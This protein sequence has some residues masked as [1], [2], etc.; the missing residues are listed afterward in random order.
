MPPRL[1][2]TTSRRLFDRAQKVLPGGVS[3]PVRAFRAVGGHPIFVKKAA[4]STLVDVDG[5]RY[6][7]F[8]MSWGP[9]IHGHAP[10][11]LVR[12]LAA[13][14][15]NG[16]SYGAP[17]PL[18]HQL[19]ER[20]RELMPSMELV[21]LVS[22]G[23]EAAMSAVRVA[24]AFT[25]RDKV[26]E[27]RGLLSR[28]RGRVPGEG[29]LRRHHARHAHQPRRAQ[30]RGRRHAAGALQRSGV[31]GRGAAPAPGPGRGDHR[32][33]DRRQHGRGAAGRRVPGRAA[34]PLHRARH[35]A[36]LRR[37]DLR[38]PGGGRRRAGRLRRAAGSDVP[39]QDHRRR[40]AGGRLRRPRRHHGP[41]GAR[42]A[43]SI[44][45]ARCRGIRWR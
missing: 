18:E 6:I 8:V 40:A 37:G 1:R 9:L 41:G 14:A 34:R 26:R 39:G 36:G 3:S 12:A 22:S 43:P 30:A 16:T 19:G 38:L 7:D 15:K 21:R 11:G 2:Q 4:G 29:R 5:N 35:R 27:V 17:S 42:R 23:T 25:G 10:P 32:G 24:R 13:A 28:P 45:L 33:A 20:V 44:R 31:G